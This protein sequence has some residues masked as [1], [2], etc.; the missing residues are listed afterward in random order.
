MFINFIGDFVLV[1]CKVI[2][3]E[4]G[5]EYD[6]VFEVVGICFFIIYLFLLC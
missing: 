6:L 4:I 1:L 3:I 2:V 5:I